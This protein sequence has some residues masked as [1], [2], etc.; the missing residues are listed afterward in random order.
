MMRTKKINE[1][2]SI[3]FFVKHNSTTFSDLSHTCFFHFH[4]SVEY[5]QSYCAHKSDDR[6]V[7]NFE[8][9]SVFTLFTF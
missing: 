4:Q 5:S 1:M 6:V 3:I 8:F 2:L 9:F 7:I